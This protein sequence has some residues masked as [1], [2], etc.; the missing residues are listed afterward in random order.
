M[1]ARMSRRFS[2][3]VFIRVDASIFYAYTHNTPVTWEI[4]QTIYIIFADLP[5]QSR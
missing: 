1:G 4:L 3:N 5:H 2:S